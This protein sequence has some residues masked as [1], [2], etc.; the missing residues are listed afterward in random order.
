[1]GLLQPTNGILKVDNCK[2]NIENQH[3]WQSHISHVPQSVFLADCTIEENIAFGL[4]KS[5]IDKDR[6]VLCAQ[7]AQIADIIETWPDKYQTRIGERGIRLSGGQRQRIGIARALYKN[8]DIIIFDEA[9]NALDND[10]EIAVMRAIEGLSKNLTILII[11]HRVTTLR[12]CDVI[13]ELNNGI[14]ANA[15]TYKDIVSKI[16]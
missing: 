10:T 16:V 1:M 13:I 2:I 7:Q 9:T 6:V 11:A 15:G 8:A 4:Y 14:I 3:N 12:N 5:E